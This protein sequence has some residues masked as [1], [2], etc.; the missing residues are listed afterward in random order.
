MWNELSNYPLLLFFEV[1]VR[2][3]STEFQF[4]QEIYSQNSLQVPSVGIEKYFITRARS[5]ETSLYI[6]HNGKSSYTTGKHRS[7]IAA[8]CNNLTVENFPLNQKMDKNAPHPNQVSPCT[9]D[10]SQSSN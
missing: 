2:W 6:F 3:P 7:N 5:D 8:H 4:P 10:K 9:A 1:N